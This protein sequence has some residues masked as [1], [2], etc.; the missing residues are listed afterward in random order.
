MTRHEDTL[1]FQ[2]DKMEKGKITKTYKIYANG[3][4]E[5]FDGSDGIRYL[6]NNYVPHHFCKL[7]L[8]MTDAFPNLK[9]KAAVHDPIN[10]EVV[11]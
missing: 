5:G 4:T 1:I 11:K 3:D 8:F 9:I 7:G 2:V 6:V 10:S